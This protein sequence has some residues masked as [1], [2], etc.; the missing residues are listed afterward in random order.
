MPDGPGIGMHALVWWPIV[1]PLV[2]AFIPRVGR[3]GAGIVAVSVLLGIVTGS[4]EELLWR[5]VYLRLFPDNVGWSRLYPSVA[6]GLWH[7]APLGVLPSR[8]PGGAA[9][10]VAYSTVLGL[11]Y[12][13]AARKTGSIRWCALSHCIHDALGLGGFAYASWLS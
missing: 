4:T 3:A 2:A 11:S 12:A 13:T 7:L 5:G 8:Y 6:F 10:F 1:V 9:G